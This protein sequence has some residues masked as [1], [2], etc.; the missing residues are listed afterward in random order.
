VSTPVVALIAAVADNGVIGDGDG[1]PWRLS[2]DLRRFRALTLGKPV[3][4]GRRTFAAIGKPLAGRTNIVVTRQAGFASAG[5]TVAH[6]L[7]AAL[8][9]A[10]DS[11]RAA[12]VAEAMVIGGGEVYAQAMA[13]AGR[14]YVTHVHASPPGTAHFPVIAADSW[15]L[16]SS[17]EFSAGENDTAATTFAVYEP[18]NPAG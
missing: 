12:G 16:V 8:D 11:A 3:V 14:L 17:E 2:T 7:D 4:M 6:D 13:R 5:V 15:R 10:L 18:R 1:M 9:L